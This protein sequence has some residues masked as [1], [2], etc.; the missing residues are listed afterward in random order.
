M[1]NDY[2]L[3]Q[4]CAAEFFGTSMIIYGGCGLVCA[5]RFASNW[6]IG[7]LGAPLV[8]GTAVAMAVYGFRDISGAHLNPAVT[9]SLAINRPDAIPKSHVLPYIAAQMG[10]ATWA[11]GINYLV[12]KKGI[13][14]FE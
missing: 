5:D 10:G 14:H 7:P 13:E 2:N 9:A 12:Y 8:F 11:A 3:F 6:K 1:S 4:K